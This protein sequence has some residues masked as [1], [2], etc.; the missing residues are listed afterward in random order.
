MKEKLEHI[1]MQMKSLLEGSSEPI[2]NSYYLNDENL[3]RTTY[4]DVKSS[5]DRLCDC[6][7]LI[8]SLMPPHPQLQMGN[9]GH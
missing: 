1:E 8:F 4:A 2:K 9:L 7:T 6:D 5:L 3:K